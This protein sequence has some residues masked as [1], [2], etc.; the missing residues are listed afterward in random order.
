MAR[1]RAMAESTLA[2]SRFIG[3]WRLESF[4][5]VLPDGTVTHPWGEDPLGMIVWDASGHFAVQVGPRDPA[6][7][8][9]YTSFFGTAHGPEGES[10]TVILRV[11]GSSAP[12]R[13]NGDQVR[14]F[15]FEE[16]GLVRM[17]PPVGPNGAQSTF[18]WRRVSG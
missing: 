6:R 11:I 10:G 18:R 16:E 9:E 7:A 5:S 2:N 14:N 17:R 15:L 12:T 1:I 3:T 4:E 8:A 13:V